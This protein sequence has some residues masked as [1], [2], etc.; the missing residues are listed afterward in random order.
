MDYSNSRPWLLKNNEDNIRTVTTLQTGITTPSKS[1]VER[2]RLCLLRKEL[3]W[4]LGNK[5]QD[6]SIAAVAAERPIED[7]NHQ[8]HGENNSRMLDHGDD[9]VMEVE[10]GTGKTSVFERNLLDHLA[11]TIA[12]L[13]QR[14]DTQEDQILMIHRGMVL[15]MEAGAGVPIKNL[16][17]GHLLRSVGDWK[18]IFASTS[19]LW[20]E[21]HVLLRLLREKGMR[22]S[23]ST[24]NILETLH[25]KILLHSFYN[26]LWS[27]C[28]DRPAKN[29]LW[30]LS[31]VIEAEWMRLKLRTKRQLRCKMPVCESAL[32]GNTWLEELLLQPS[33]LLSRGIVRLVRRWELPRSVSEPQPVSWPMDHE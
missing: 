13:V 14:L 33:G 25:G 2:T 24:E 21:L 7:R 22:G 8:D 19:L 6:E 32:G 11:L 30:R 10:T 1:E 12:P 16:W 27:P 17:Y 5:H 3:E 26:K 18:D 20:K 15:M 9:N 23:P 29:W 28:Y 31:M 4:V